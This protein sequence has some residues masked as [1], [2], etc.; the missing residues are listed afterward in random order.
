MILLD[1]SNDCNDLFEY[2]VEKDPKKTIT[3]GSYLFEE[4]MFAFDSVSVD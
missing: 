1:Y 4:F 3:P 2:T